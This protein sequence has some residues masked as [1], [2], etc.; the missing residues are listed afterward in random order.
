M[1]Y[2]SLVWKTVS[3]FIRRFKTLGFLLTKTNVE[4]RHAQQYLPYSRTVTPFYLHTLYA[5]SI[6]SPFSS[7]SV[8]ATR[9][10][11]VTSNNMYDA[12]GISAYAYTGSWN[13]TQKP[14]Y[15]YD[16]T[17][18]KTGSSWLPASTHYWPGN[19]Y[20]LKFFAYAP[21]NNNAYQLSG[22]IAGAPTVTCTIPDNVAEQQDLL[23]AA[24]EEINGGAM[25]LLI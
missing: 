23:V 7:D 24:S 5:D 9:S 6:A 12:F 3:A 19:A 20:K 22:Q 25:R 2:N 10:I 14:N 17:V 21:Q 1:K 4:Q 15:M 8:P 18:S 11:P 16:V 13:N